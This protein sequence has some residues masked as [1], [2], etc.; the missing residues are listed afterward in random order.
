[1]LDIYVD[2]DACPVKDE[3]LKVVARHGLNV[4]F[5]SNAWMRIP[6]RDG[7][8]LVVVDDHQIGRA[9]V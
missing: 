4:V 1:M 9:H 8:T 2:A 5:V 6:G 7:V 3:V